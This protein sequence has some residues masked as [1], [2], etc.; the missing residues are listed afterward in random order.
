MTVLDDLIAGASAEDRS[1]STLLRQVK[2]L[3][4][5]LKTLQLA[6]WVDHE[7]LG[8][9]DPA[10]LPKYRGPFDAEVLGYFSGPSGQV[11]KNAAIPPV[12]FPAEYR[13]GMLFKITFPQPIAEIESLSKS[14]GPLEVAWP[15]DAL[16]L[17]NS[18]ILGGQV[19]IYEGMGILHAWQRV[20]QSQL[21]AIIDNVRTRILELALSIEE[22]APEAGQKGAAPPDADRLQQIIMNVYGG[23]PNIAVASSHVSQSVQLPSPGD[24]IALFSVLAE[25][26]VEAGELH[27]LQ[28]LLDHE[29]AVDMAGE[30][31][32]ETSSW[33]GRV[34][35]RLSSASVDVMSGA[36]GAL[37]AQALQAYLFGPHR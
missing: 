19:Q 8:Y 2:V 10:Q 3:A 9:P 34:V 12:S 35:T 15:A 17:A 1:V 14:K 24:R 29:E 18:M 5:R 28:D 25:L 22:V 21:M 30:M 32:L 13:E 31:N 4:S 36:G 26:G 23:T 6:E 7:L 37:V 16:A 20:S 11:L 33:V 27:E